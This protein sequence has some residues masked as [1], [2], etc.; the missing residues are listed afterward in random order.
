MKSVGGYTELDRMRSYSAVFS[1]TSFSKVLKGHDLSFID[2]KIKRYDENT[3]KSG[4][5]STYLEYI[6]HIYAELSKNYRNEYFYKNSFINNLLLKEYGVKDT[7][8]INE[9]RVGNSIADIVLFNGSSKAFEIKTE[10]DSKRRLKGQIADYTKIFD[11]CYIITDESL[12]EKYSNENDWVGLIALQKLPRSIKMKEVRKAKRNETINP[13]TLI[14]SIR[15]SEYK[16]IVQQFYG[17]LPEM[18]S[19]NMFDVCFQL[20]KEIPLDI[21]RSLFIDV[22]K[23][24]KSNTVLL[25]SFQKELRQLA[26]AMQ[27]DEK[28]YQHLL[29]KLNNPINL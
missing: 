14:R 20:M 29:A 5:V 23:T 9:F 10:L 16:S 18:N 17:E 27:I 2:S 1:S 15:T 21:L 28:K 3:I 11:E 6:R 12:I 24:R 8:A 22:L 26:L 25:K 4:K 13:E 19:F 7:I